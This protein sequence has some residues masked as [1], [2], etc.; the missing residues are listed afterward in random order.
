MSKQHHPDLSKDA[1]A[2]GRFQMIQE[3][4]EVLG[5]AVAK[6]D[7]DTRMRGFHS[8]PRP[9]RTGEGPSVSEFD[10]WRRGAYQ[11]RKDFGDMS[12]DDFAEFQRIWRARREQQQ[13]ERW[14]A[15]NPFRGTSYTDYQH[16][17][18]YSTHAWQEMRKHFTDKG[19]PPPGMDGFQKM[20]WVRAQQM[21]E[22]DRQMRMLA[23]SVFGITMMLMLV[24]LMFEMAEPSVFSDYR[25][26][27]MK[28]NPS[29]QFW[30]N[31]DSPM[32]DSPRP[33]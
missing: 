11:A 10:P 13:K 19:P 12:D 22:E 4:Y 26:R 25:E 23:I 7:Y 2:H 27:T 21:H 28:M 29:R 14:D 33:D 5:N 1:N 6:R 24:S 17:S 30:S 31:H 9:T 15:N 20:R 16:A 3:A 18:R 8:R 32:K